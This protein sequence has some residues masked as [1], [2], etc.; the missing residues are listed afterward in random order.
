MMSRVCLSLIYCAVL[1][2][3]CSIPFPAYSEEMQTPSAAGSNSIISRIII[4]IRDLPRDDER[5]KAMAGNLVFLK[6]GEPFSEDRLRDSIDALTLANEFRE[7]H[8]DSKEEAD[9]ISLFFQLT[10][11]RRIKDITIT[12]QA[13]LFEREI[14][15][16]ITIYSGDAFVREDLPKQAEL[17]TALYQREGFIR[18]NVTI[19][20]L[21]D[22]NDGNFIINITIEKGAY[23]SFDDIVIRGNRSFSDTRLKFKMKSWRATLRPG[24]SGRFIEEDLR[25]DIEG[26][27]SFYRSR[28]YADVTIDH[29]MK[30][31]A[32]TGSVSVAMTITEGPRYDITFTGNKEFGNMT[33]QKDLVLFESGNRNDL[34]LKRSIRN[35]RERYRKAGYLETRVSTV[36]DRK[37]E[38]EQ[39]VRSIALVIDEGPQTIVGSITIEGNRTLDEEKIKGQMLTRLPGFMEK[40]AYVPEKLEEDMFAI[41][42]LYTREGYNAAVIVDTVRW[43]D[44]K[45]HVDITLTITEAL[46][47]VISSAHIEGVDA[48][49]REEAYDAIKLREGEPFRRYMIRSDENALAQLISEKGYPHVTVRSHTTVSEDTSQADIMYQVAEGPK[50]AMGEVYFSGNFRTKE[51]VLRNELELN[52]GEPFSLTKMLEQQRN[53][54]NMNIFNSVRFKTIGLK[55]NSDTAHLIVEVEE[56]KPYFF[57]LGGGYESDRGLFAQTTVG[58]HNLFGTNKYGWIGGKISEIGYRGDMGLVEPRFLKT[59]TTLSLNLFAERLEEFNQEFGTKS[60]GASVGFTRKMSPSLTAG[61]SFS[62]EQRE[63]YSLGSATGDEFQSRSILVTTPSLNYDTRDSFIRPTK[64][65]F[66]Y[67]SVDVSTGLRNS[68]DNFLKYRVDVRYYVTPFN[69]LTLAWLGRAGYISTYGSDGTVPK[70]QLFYL[71]G[72]SDVRGF[73]ENLLRYD[74]AG[75]PV[76]GRAA[77]S[78]SFEARIDLGGNFE[79]APFIDTG[80][81]RRTFDGGGSDSFRSSVG[82]GLRYITPIGP[83]GLLY[84]HKLDRRD[85]ESAGRFHFS[86]GYTF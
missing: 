31:N 66:S 35:I 34:G 14:L 62:L 54:R 85:G 6:E 7:I 45:R 44:D 25:K 28:G 8:V 78:G 81:V 72:T 37:Q 71:G 9:G 3:V 53:I 2:T 69:R 36:E 17:I 24:S 49:T 56:K 43:S 47:T 18:P 79:L 83:I 16:A 76:G 40:G 13:P 10:P 22:E 74:A 38:D 57:E 58:D 75:D 27:T 68:L 55:E 42:S 84:G 59:R 15:N 26:L 86:I 82:I 12:G 21:K 48:V 51:K 63:Q 20:A 60:Y 4:E 29:D 46:Q 11:L 52:K 19:P 5:L 32:E 73:D 77:L 61:L 64:G 80:S 30:K 33:L 50:V 41:K 65:I 23:Y 67:C 70:D 39:T 1:L